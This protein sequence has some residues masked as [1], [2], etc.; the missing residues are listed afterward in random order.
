MFIETKDGTAEIRIYTHY[1][2]A[3]FESGDRQAAYQACYG[4]GR[5]SVNFTNNDASRRDASGR[6]G[7]C[8]HSSIH[9]SDKV[10]SDVG[11]DSPTLPFPQFFFI[12]FVLPFCSSWDGRV[13]RSTPTRVQ[14][15]DLINIQIMNK[16][17]QISIYQFSFSPLA[18]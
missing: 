18:N 14:A 3:V 9:S 11:N 2:R 15:I 13:E 16:L 10:P 17:Q 5:T 12:V 1:W 8:R 6:I 4:R 7:H